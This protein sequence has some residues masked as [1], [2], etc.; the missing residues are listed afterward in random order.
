MD[1][2]VRECKVLNSLDPLWHTAASNAEPLK[3]EGTTAPIDARPPN[4]LSDRLRLPLSL[5][6]QGLLLLLD[7]TR[8][9]FYRQSVDKERRDH[10]QSLAV[11]SFLQTWAYSLRQKFNFE[12]PRQHPASMK[13][14]QYEPS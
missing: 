2:C 11:L 14:V 8:H 5:I 10:S 13:D 12:S 7:P 6:L 3:E 1:C 9:T 4:T